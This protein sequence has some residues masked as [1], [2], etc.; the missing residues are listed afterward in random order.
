M[1]GTKRIKHEI[2]KS[3]K[4]KENTPKPQDA[5]EV[6]CSLP[7]KY[8][9]ET[10]LLGVS[11]SPAPVAVTLHSCSARLS[12]Q[13]IRAERQCVAL[14]GMGQEYDAERCEHPIVNWWQPL[15]LR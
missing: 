8:L 15:T 1:S 11:R 7:Q 2:P 5:S 10:C 12:S 9:H 4:E 3:K 13:I 6:S 14:N